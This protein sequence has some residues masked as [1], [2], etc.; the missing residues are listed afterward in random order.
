MIYSSSAAHSIRTGTGTKD[1]LSR[2][3]YFFPTEV[4]HA[5]VRMPRAIL[6]GR[7]TRSAIRLLALTIC[8]TTLAGTSAASGTSHGKH[9]K[10]HGFRIVRPAWPGVSPPVQSGGVC[11]GMA[12]SFDCKIWPPPFDEDPD[13]KVSGS[14]GA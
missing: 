1:L 11:P 2:Q 12:R 3:E 14:D 6:E 9:I 4:Y 5:G 8:A 10:K 7:M 13:R